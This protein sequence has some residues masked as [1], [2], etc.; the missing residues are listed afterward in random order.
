MIQS[1]FRPELVLL[2]AFTSGCLVAMAGALVSIALDVRTIT[3]RLRR[4]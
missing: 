4:R 2:L 3:R 1:L